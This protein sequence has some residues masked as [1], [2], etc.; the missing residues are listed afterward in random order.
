MPEKKDIHLVSGAD[1]ESGEVLNL[2][3]E[4]VRPRTM[5]RFVLV[6]A[7]AEN[8]ARSVQ[9]TLSRPSVD[10]DA[11]EQPEEFTIEFENLLPAELLPKLRGV[12][13]DLSELLDP[14]D[15][16]ERVIAHSLAGLLADSASLRVERDETLDP[17]AVTFTLRIG[18]LYEDSYQVTLAELSDFINPAETELDPKLAAAMDEALGPLPKGESS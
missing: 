11:E 16:P 5:V 6:T 13:V 1:A 15:D 14:H 2:H 8:R 10:L 3:F 7:A 4:G 12:Y 18:E 9:L 17:D